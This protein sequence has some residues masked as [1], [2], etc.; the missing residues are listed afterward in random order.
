LSLTDTDNAAGLKIGDVDD[1]SLSAGSGLPAVACDGDGR[2]EMGCNS[3]NCLAGRC[4]N[5]GSIF[6]LFRLLFVGITLLLSSSSALHFL[7]LVFLVHHPV[8]RD[9]RHLLAHVMA[10]DFTVALKYS[11]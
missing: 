6:V 4:R 9:D 5:L 8:N 3:G 11:Q 7:L 2:Q 1:N 10:S